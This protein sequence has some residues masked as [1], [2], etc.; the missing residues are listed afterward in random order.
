[1]PVYKLKIKK[2]EIL[3]V[4]NGKRKNDCNYGVVIDI[5]DTTHG[6]YREMK[7]QMVHSRN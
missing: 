2:L 1:V 3:M 7:K 5:A 4:I 6:K